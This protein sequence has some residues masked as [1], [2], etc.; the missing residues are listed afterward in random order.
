[1][2]RHVNRVLQPLGRL[3][4]IP[5]TSYRQ[6]GQMLQH[7]PELSQDVS[8][9]DEYQ[10]QALRGI[11]VKEL[12]GDLVLDLADTLIGDLVHTL[13]LT[14]NES[15]EQTWLDKSSQALGM[16]ESFRRDTKGLVVQHRRHWTNE[17]GGTL[18]V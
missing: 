16:F 13:A 5:W 7:S 14:L 6:R 17:R 15:L 9:L 4:E 11:L 10:D 1:M 3:E 12:L 2:D 8:A 18:L